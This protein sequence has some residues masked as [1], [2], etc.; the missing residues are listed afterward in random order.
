MEGTRKKIILAG[1]GTLG[2]VSPLLAVAQ[3]YSAHYLFIGSVAGPEKD[4]VKAQGLPFVAI[5]SGKLRRYFSW[6]NFVD[7]FKIKFAFWQSLRI[8]RQ[9]KPDLILTAGSFVAVPVAWAAWCKKVPVIVHQQDL[10]IGLA[11]KF[12]APVAKKITVTFPEQAKDFKK[13][14]VVVTGNPVRIIKNISQPLKPL[15][16]ITGGGLGARGLN[17]FVVNFIPQLLKKY[18]VHHILGPRNWD[19]AL[20]LEGYFPYKFVDQDMMS[21]L[22]QAEIVISRGGMSLISEV[23]SLKK[24]LILIPLPGSHQEVNANFF[25]KHNAAWVVK[26]GSYQIMERYLDKLFKDDKFKI[27]LGNNLSKL[28]PRN[29]VGNYV[30]LIEEVLS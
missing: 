19:Q 5:T 9:F 13:S 3:K 22:A 21:L 14:K 18:E 24:A 1:G 30:K 10:K 11:N 15:V 17:N 2:S 6:H 7:V 27:D 16:M 28:F 26:Q 23:A 4:L 25:A 20:E 12:M 29:A 8:I